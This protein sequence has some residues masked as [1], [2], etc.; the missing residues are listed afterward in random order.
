MAL[1]A[2]PVKKPRWA[3]VG[4][5]ITE[6]SEIK[7]DVGWIVEKPPHQFFNWLMNLYYQWVE[8]FESA[9]DLSNAKYDYYV[10]ALGTHTDLE[11][12]VDDPLVLAGSTALILEDQILDAQIVIDREMHIEILPS[13]S[14]T[15]GIVNV[16]AIQ[17]TANDVSIKGG[18]ISGFNVGGTSAIEIVTTVLRTMIHEIRFSGNTNDVSDVDGNA[19]IFNNFNS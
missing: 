8:Y 1:L 19:L 10:G 15:K 4:G 12:L 9:T 18:K 16:N 13:V 3:N 11:A 6:P 14:I 7:K 2:K 17:I 5:A